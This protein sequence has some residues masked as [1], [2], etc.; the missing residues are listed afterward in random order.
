MK[1]LNVL[2]VSFLV[3]STSA[4][5]SQDAA[6]PVS[7]VLDF[8]AGQ[9]Q[10]SD[11]FFGALDAN[12][13]KV[14]RLDLEII[15]RQTED[16]LGYEL[17]GVTGTAEKDPVRCGT[18][19]TGLVENYRAD[20]DLSFGHTENFH[21]PITIHV[22]DRLDFPFNEVRCGAENVGATE[23]T[24]LHLTGTFVVAVAPIPTANQ[25]VLYPVKR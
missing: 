16:S 25:Y 21:A 7:A 13:G 20:Y 9:G 3:L 12:A 17:R 5:W 10:A 4:A 6:T 11:D 22:G 24:H 15:P 23:F 18:A 2:G 19:Y 1:F 8:T 14:I